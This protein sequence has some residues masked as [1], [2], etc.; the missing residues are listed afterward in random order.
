MPATAITSRERIRRVLNHERPD[1]VPCDLGGSSVTGMHVSVVYA[2]R[3]ALGL[4]PPGAP[5]KVIDPFQML[6]EIKDDLRGLIGIDTVPLEG[7][8]TF[9]GFRQENW[10]PWTTFDGTPVLVPREFNTEPDVN[11]RIYQYPQGDRGAKP[12]GVMPRGGF[13]FDAIQRGAP[14][15]FDDLRVEDNVAEY[16]P[17][18]DDELQ[19]LA[20]ESERLFRETDKAIFASFPG[21]GFGDIAWLPAPFLKQPKGI[22]GY[23]DWFASLAERPQFVR[24][25]FERQCAVAL[26][27]LARLYDAVGDRVSVLFLTGADYGTQAGPSLSPRLFAELFAPFYARLNEWIHSRTPWRVFIHSCGGVR[28]LVPHLIAAGFDVLN[29]VQCSAAG[30]DPAGL[31]EDYGDRLVFWGGGVDTQRTLPYGTPEEVVEE[32]R[33]RMNI[34][35]RGGGFVFAAVHNLQPGTPVA[36]LLAMLEAY[37]QHRSD[38]LD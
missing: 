7:T 30:M 10:K 16:G 8:R 2:L 21:G 22:R 17:I 13:Y 3:Q 11:G 12:S 32:I 38:P 1:R 24:K 37:W 36:N 29:P 26:R 35:G 23:D 6:G 28:P 18:P 33:T 5:V 9:F 19:H 25:V 31:K 27:N 20:G 34:L 4:D 15:D 14:V